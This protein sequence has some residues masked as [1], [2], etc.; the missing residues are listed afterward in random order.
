MDDNL[1]H[2]RVAWGNVNRPFPSDK[3]D[4]LTKRM[5]EA[6]KDQDV[7][8]FDGYVGADS[9]HRIAV[10]VITDT[11][12]QNLFATQLFIRPNE[13]ELESFVPDFTIV[14]LTDF[15]ADPAVDGTHSDA[16]V[17]LNLS[18]KLILIGMKMIS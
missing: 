10:R 9:S 13:F 6:I 3:F 8:I 18:K 14:S 17:V 2:D 4:S 16:F 11:N 15:Q 5:Q 1:T 7:K 12:W